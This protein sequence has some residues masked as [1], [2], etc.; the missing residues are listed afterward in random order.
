LV[1]TQNGVTSTVMD[2]IIGFK[3][4]AS[5]WNAVET[6]SGFNSTYYNYN[7]ALYQLGGSGTQEAWNFSL[8]RSVRISMI[9]RSNPSTTTGTTAYHNSF[10]GGPYQV[11]GT[12]I[13]VNPRNLSM[14]DDQTQALQ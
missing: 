2:Q 1:R 12:A 8:V 5:L 11:R 14:S 4:G 13:I 9:A 3:A 10:D 7:S 6:G